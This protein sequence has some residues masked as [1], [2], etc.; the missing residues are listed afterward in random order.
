M[1]GV[2]FT[3]KNE[4]KD[5][6]ADDFAK[7]RQGHKYRISRSNA[8][9]LIPVEYSNEII[10]EVS[11]ESSALTLMKKLPNMTRKQK[12]IPVLQS[13][14]VAGF[15]NGDNGLK[16]VS[17]VEWGNKVI[18]AEEIAVIIPIPEAVLDDADHDI[19]AEIKPSIMDTISAKADEYREQLKELVRQEAE[20]R[21]QHEE[22][23][24]NAGS[25]V[26]YVSTLSDK[27]GALNQKIAEQEL[28]FRTT[29]NALDN[30]VKKA[31]ESYDKQTAAADRYYQSS[32]VSN[33]TN[34][35]TS[36]ITNV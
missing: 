34:N 15:V 20:L 7:R 32:S 30:Y 22:M 21:R 11:R 26:S 2:I 31:V 35:S 4:R 10:K 5:N 36:K 14:P 28:K 19:W 16:A 9:A 25:G 23:N 6:Y 29:Q 1:Q 13:L 18:T 17:N 33:S 12:S 3:T 27:I 24:R 8:E